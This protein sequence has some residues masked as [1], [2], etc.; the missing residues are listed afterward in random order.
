LGSGVVVVKDPSSYTQFALSTS[1]VEEIAKATYARP[2]P[3]HDS[4]NP[5]CNRE[6]IIQ[7]QWREKELKEGPPYVTPTVHLRCYPTEHYTKRP[8][9]TYEWMPDEATSRSGSS[10]KKTCD[11]TPWSQSRFCR[12]M[13]YGTILIAGDSL[14]WEH[15]A[16]LVQLNGL[17][18][19]Q[20]YQHQS[21]LL[22]MNIGQ[23]VCNGMTRIVYRRDDRLTNL[24][25]ALLQ[26]DPDFFPTVLVLN[27]G[28]HY[29]ND[30]V[31]LDNLRMNLGYVRQ[32]L[33]QCEN[34]EIKCHFFW[35]TTVPGHPNCTQNDVPNNNLEEM[36]ARV[37]KF[38]YEGKM[39]NY[40]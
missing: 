27:R 39:I 4:E 30:T 28:A 22:H 13:R 38:P 8:Y 17:H 29:A 3:W 35:R 10:S 40:Q 25:G 11:M 5:L 23:T 9:K 32:W 26:R 20:N 37:T 21:N 36:E 7:G 1:E 34:L 14:S 6:Q 16:S 24:S 33:R 15:Y 18:T 2:T 19:H 31:L 12:I